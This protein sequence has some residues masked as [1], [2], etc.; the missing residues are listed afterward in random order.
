MIPITYLFH[1]LFIELEIKIPEIEAEALE[2][3][4]GGAIR[5]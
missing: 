2:L 4:P 3:S 5:F 1:V